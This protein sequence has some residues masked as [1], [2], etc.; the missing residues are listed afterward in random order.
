MIKVWKLWWL[1]IFLF[2]SCS[3]A[4]IQNRGTI[5]VNGSRGSQQLILERN[6]QCPI[7]FAVA[8]ICAQLIPLQD[9]AEV[10]KQNS[11]KLRF[12]EHNVGTP[13]GPF[14]D[15]EYAIEVMPWMKM[16]GGVDHGSRW[17]VIVS[18]SLDSTGM[19]ILG[20]YHLDQVRFTMMGIWELWIKLK[21]EDGKLFDE[22]VQRIRI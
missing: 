5:A 15:L 11:F 18:H 14:V 2:L 17:D 22:A 21:L 20:E 12:W 4:P 9:R 16:P 8:N 19:K 3:C 1:Y 7:Y 13:S 10:I 6:E